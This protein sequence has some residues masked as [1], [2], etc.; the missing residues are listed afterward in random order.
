MVPFALV[1]GGLFGNWLADTETA[2]HWVLLA[3]AAPI[4][5]IALTRG[6]R[7]NL[8]LGAA[9]LTLMLVGVAHWIGASYE[10][11]LTV[12]GVVLVITAHIRNLMHRH[13]HA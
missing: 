4:S 7:G 2:V 5:L 12:I 6:P 1:L 11:A 9:G 8:Y 3:L 13:S 10:V